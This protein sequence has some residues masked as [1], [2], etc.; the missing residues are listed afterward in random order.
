MQ[1][2]LPRHPCLPVPAGQDI[3][4]EASSEVQ[5]DHACEQRDA[6]EEL[7]AEPVTPGAPNKA[8][9]A[10]CSVN[11]LFRIL[12][13]AE[14]KQPCVAQH[15]TCVTVGHNIS[16]YALVRHPSLTCCVVR[17]I[18]GAAGFCQIEFLQLVLGILQL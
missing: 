13:R 3:Q 14:S 17:S 6:S 5:S 4:A 9:D 12:T 11:C 16:A 15:E 10:A 2:H 7:E 1:S 18:S 8:Q